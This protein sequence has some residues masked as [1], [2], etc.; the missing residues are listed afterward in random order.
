[1][2]QVLEIAQSP[3]KTSFNPKN[4]EQLK[5]VHEQSLKEQLG[6]SN[7]MQSSH[8]EEFL[9]AFGYSDVQFRGIV[10]NFLSDFFAPSQYKITYSLYLIGTQSYW[11]RIHPI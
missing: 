2:Y 3:Y 5:R 6:K 11:C 10:D 9:K 7:L 1:V 4:K 8:L